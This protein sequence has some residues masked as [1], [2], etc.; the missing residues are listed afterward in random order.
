METNK[1]TQVSIISEED[2][3]K[4]LETFKLAYKKNEEKYVEE[5]IKVEDVVNLTKGFSGKNALLATTVIISIMIA[6]PPKEFM[7]LMDTA[8]SISRV[9]CLEAMNE[10]FED[11][12][13]GADNNID[14]NLW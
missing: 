6:I 10:F 1:K 2:I 13:K 7:A 9:K 14:N 8:K 3:K 5:N 11:K 4:A 12:A